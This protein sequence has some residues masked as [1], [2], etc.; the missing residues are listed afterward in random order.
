MSHQR[1]LPLVRRRIEALLLKTVA[2]GCTAGE[3][4]AA[5]EKAEELTAKYGIDPDDFRWPPRPSTIFSSASQARAHRSRH[6]PPHRA[7]AKA[8]AAPPRH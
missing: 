3:A 1:E 8:S 2:N 5:Y 6:G 4:A 7:G